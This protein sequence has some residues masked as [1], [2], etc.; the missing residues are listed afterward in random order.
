MQDD[1]E[2]NRFDMFRDI[3]LQILS[4][5]NLNNCSSAMQRNFP[6]DYCHSLW[7]LRKLFRPKVKSLMANTYPNKNSKSFVNTN[8]SFIKNSCATKRSIL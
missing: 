1:L 6:Q 3:Y 8:N 7:H 4:I 2:G 5:F